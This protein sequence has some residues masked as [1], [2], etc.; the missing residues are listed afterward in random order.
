MIWQ[1][2]PMICQET[3]HHFGSIQT[4]DTV[5]TIGMSS[6]GSLTSLQFHPLSGK[7]QVLTDGRGG[8]LLYA[9]R[10][11]YITPRLVFDP[12]WDTECNFYSFYMQHVGYHTIKVRKNSIACSREITQN[13]F[14][15]EKTVI[16]SA[17][18]WAS[19]L[20][21]LDCIARL[22]VK[23]TLTIWVLANL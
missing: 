2:T 8:E 21:V 7:A 17:L 1:L 22:F 12:E 16:V 9:P 4:Q 13:T 23:T 20:K 15:S 6:F 3:F 5:H 11:P 14:L 10:R 19:T 18:F